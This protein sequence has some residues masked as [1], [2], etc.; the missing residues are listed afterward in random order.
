MCDNMNIVRIVF[1]VDKKQKSKSNFLISKY[2]LLIE[3]LT[4]G[5]SPAELTNRTQM[6]KMETK[7]EM[8]PLKAFGI[9]F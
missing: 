3:I 4:A 1:V 7:M 2:R 5:L 9:V 6:N 8:N